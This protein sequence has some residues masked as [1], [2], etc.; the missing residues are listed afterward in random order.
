[1]N[2]TA[3]TNNPSTSKSSDKAN[4]KNYLE[5]ENAVKLAKNCNALAVNNGMV[6]VGCFEQA[7]EVDKK[8]NINQWD[9][10]KLNNGDIIQSIDFKQDAVYVL[11]YNSQ[12]GGSFRVLS[13]AIQGKQESREYDYGTGTS[14][15]K[16]SRVHHDGYGYTNKL[17]IV[18]DKLIIPCRS[19][20]RL[21]KYSLS[22]E[23]IQHIPLALSSNQTS[24]CAFGSDCVI[25]AD[26]ESSKMYKVNIC[27]GEIQWT[28]E[29]VASPQGVTSYGKT[30]VLV[31]SFGRR[32]VCLLH[33]ET[34][35]I[36]I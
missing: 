7:F 17:A 13:P 8:L 11:I 22:G 1:M 34:G 6:Y 23:I 33:S 20:K 5:L 19:N 3:L 25:V 26:Y 4:G 12:N 35:M 16:P 18:S 24:E 31:W 32:A 36:S 21:V 28:C 9:Q 27:T 29:Q 15:L 30:Y 10:I 2:E 14:A